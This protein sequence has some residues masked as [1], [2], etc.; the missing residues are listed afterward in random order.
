MFPNDKSEWADND[1]DGFGDNID[2]CPITPG[3]STSG[4]VGCV[5]TDGDTWAD[6]EDFLPDDAT[7]YVDTDGDSFGDNSDGTNGDFCPYDAGTSVYD[8]A[9]CPDDDFDGW[10]LSLIHI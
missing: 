1:S 10:S 6:N 3:T 4:N 5:D 9:G 8:V 7:Q 2:F